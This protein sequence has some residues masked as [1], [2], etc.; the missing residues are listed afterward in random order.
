MCEVVCGYV[1]LTKQI[2]VILGCL[3]MDMP[4]AC[5]FNYQMLHT[6]LM[7]QGCL[8]FDVNLKFSDRFLLT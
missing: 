8:Q 2:I 5:H 3:H 6:L 7:N 4:F 1:S